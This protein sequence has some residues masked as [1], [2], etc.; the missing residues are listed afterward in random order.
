[1]I[2]RIVAFLCVLQVMAFPTKSAVLHL[3]ICLF[4]SSKKALKR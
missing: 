2:V 3:Y 1:M 4:V